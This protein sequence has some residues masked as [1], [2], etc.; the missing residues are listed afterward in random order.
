MLEG[1]QKEFEKK[2]GRVKWLVGL[3][4]MMGRGNTQCA[5]TCSTFFPHHPPP[6]PTVRNAAIFMAANSPINTS[7][8]TSSIESLIDSMNVWRKR[9]SEKEG[10]EKFAGFLNSALVRS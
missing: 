9:K 5:G 10:V 8:P 7:G 1:G 3:M 2:E 4:K 6:P